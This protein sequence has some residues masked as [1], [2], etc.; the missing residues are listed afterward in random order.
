MKKIILSALV[1]FFLY[2]CSTETVPNDALIDDTAYRN[3]ADLQLGFNGAMGS[4]S[5]RSITTFNSIFTDECRIGADNGGQQIQLH[6]Q[7]IDANEGQSGAIWVGLYASINRFNR[8]IEAAQNISPASNSEQ[9]QYNNILGYCYAMRA[10]CHLDLMNHYT[11]DISDLNSLAVPYI[12]IVVRSERLPRN[13]VAEVRD[14]IIE[15]LEIADG[16]ITN[17]NVTLPTKRFVNFVKAKTYFLTNNYSAALTAASLIIDEADS[18]LTLSSGSNYQD[19]FA[20][21]S[22]GEIIFK[23]FRTQNE[24]FAGGIWYFTGTGG[25]FMEMSNKMFLSLPPTA[26]V[27]RDVLFDEPSFIA[28]NT[29]LLI[30][31]YPGRN[32]IPFFNDD[33]VIRLSELFLIKAE[34]QARLSQFSDAVVTL[35]EIRTARGAELIDP[36]TVTTFLNAANTILAERFIELGYEGHRYVDIKRLRNVTNVGIVRNSSDCGGGVPCDLAVSD[37][38]FTLPIPTREMDQNPNMV[39]NPGY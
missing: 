1:V 3:V 9:I 6:N 10:L 23:R 32:G 26:D 19:M 13:T 29:K 18:P 24:G 25:V 12:K 39:Q 33:K 4:Y 21:D 34:C 20:N 11:V 27:R 8:I 31:K 37:H 7:Q 2:S 30:N 38:R 28:D 36:A 14:G 17:T 5:N 35:N 22:N 16:L 15:D